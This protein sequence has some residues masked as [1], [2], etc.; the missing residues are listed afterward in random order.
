MSTLHENCT[1]EYTLTAMLAGT[2][3]LAVVPVLHGATEVSPKALLPMAVRLVG[4]M[5]LDRLLQL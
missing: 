1:P 5:M 4:S 3:S 2:N